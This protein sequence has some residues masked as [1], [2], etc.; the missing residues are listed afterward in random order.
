M[1][2]HYTSYIWRFKNNILHNDKAII[3]EVISPQGSSSSFVLKN[4]QIKYSKH[5]IKESSTRT[6][7]TT[8]REFDSMSMSKATKQQPN[9]SWMDWSYEKYITLHKEIAT[10]YTQTLETADKGRVEITRERERSRNGTWELIKL[11]NH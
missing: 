2:E 9:V 1:H 10:T 6:N 7:I 8:T 4:K 11:N 3:Q 5:L